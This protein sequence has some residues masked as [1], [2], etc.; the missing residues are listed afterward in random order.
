MRGIKKRTRLSVDSPQRLLTINAYEQGVRQ[1]PAVD[2]RPDQGR[3]RWRMGLRT[4]HRADLRNLPF[5]PSIKERSRPRARA[6]AASGHMGG[7]ASQLPK[8]PALLAVRPLQPRELAH[9]H[10]PVRPREP[11]ARRDLFRLV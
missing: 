4:P 6:Y 8:R 7:L 9:N 10:P 1:D 5:H 3:A 11:S 2:R